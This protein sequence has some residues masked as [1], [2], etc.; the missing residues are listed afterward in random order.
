M[1]VGVIVEMESMKDFV[2]RQ[3][4]EEMRQPVVR[5]TREPSQKGRIEIFRAI[6]ETIMSMIE[7]T[8]LRANRV[9]M[10]T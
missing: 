3:S 4:R 2:D 8:L 1:H 6:H 7:V 5:M 9:K 10:T